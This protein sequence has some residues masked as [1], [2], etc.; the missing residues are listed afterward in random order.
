MWKQNQKNYWKPEMCSKLQKSLVT[1]CI[2][3]SCFPLNPVSLYSDP[4]PLIW[5][6]SCTEF[7]TNQSAVILMELCQNQHD[8]PRFKMRLHGFLLLHDS[9]GILSAAR[10]LGVQLEAVLWRALFVSCMVI[11]IPKMLTVMVHQSSLLHFRVHRSFKTIY[12]AN[13]K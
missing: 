1:E 3:Q 11:I 8:H 4:P 6:L 10:Q 5:V 2:L 9:F 13:E 12:V 7:I